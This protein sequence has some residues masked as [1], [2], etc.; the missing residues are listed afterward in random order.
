MVNDILEELLD[1]DMETQT[2]ISVV[3]KHLQR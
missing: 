3:D 2:G 1:P